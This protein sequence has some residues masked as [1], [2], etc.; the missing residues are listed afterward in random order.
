MIKKS[1]FR[2]M[3]KAKVTSL[4]L[5]LHEGCKVWMKGYHGG[6]LP[7]N[8]YKLDNSQYDQ[9]IDDAFDYLVMHSVKTKEEFA[10]SLDIEFEASIR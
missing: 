7:Q 2:E 8:Q 4:N 3:F 5:D 9:I 10:E 6:I 1:E